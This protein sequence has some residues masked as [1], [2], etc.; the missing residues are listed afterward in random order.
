MF[1]GDTRVYR[2]AGNQAFSPSIHHRLQCMP[3]LPPGYHLFK[4]F[5]VSSNDTDLT[6]SLTDFCFG[7]DGILDVQKAL[8]SR[9]PHR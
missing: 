5:A 4:P 8:Q 2:S 7:S 9:L 3:S 6:C 1:T